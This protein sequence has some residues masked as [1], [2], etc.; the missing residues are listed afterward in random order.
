MVD[1]V[2]KH[3]LW[4]A[5]LL[6]L[7]VAAIGFFTHGQTYG[8]GYEAAKILLSGSTE[9]I[10]P[11]YG[12]F[13]MISTLLSYLSGIPGG[14]FAP[15]LSAGAGLGATIAQFF[16]PE[17]LSAIILLTTVAYFS[18]VVQSPITCFIIVSEMTDTAT[19]SM[20]LPIMLTSLM[21]TGVSR[22]ICRESI[23]HVLSS[24]FIQMLQ[25]RPSY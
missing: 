4:V 1:V 18:G 12:F 23:Y 24:R 14:I 13:K 21:A 20:L 5:G 22:V 15:S 3:P 10:A 11:F 7:I 16:S 25:A 6:G 8:S 2:R 9:E 19:T 17:Y